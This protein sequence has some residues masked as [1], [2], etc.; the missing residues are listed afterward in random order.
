MAA[1]FKLGVVVSYSSNESQFLAA[2][3]RELAICADQIVYSVGS[4]LYDM[5]RE[6]PLDLSMLEPKFTVATYA[7]EEDVKSNPR[8]YH[9]LARSAGFAA[10][11][12]DVTWVLFLDADEIPDGRAVKAFFQTNAKHFFEKMAYKFACHWYFVKSTW[13][14]TSDEDSIVLVH[15]S[16]LNAESLADVNERDGIVRRCPG[17][18][19]RR[20]Y[21]NAG[22]QRKPMFHHYSWVRS[23]AQA[24]HKVSTW[25]HRGD[26][27]D[28]ADLVEA[29]WSSPDPPA[30]DFVDFV[31][32][33]A[34]EVVEDTF[35]LISP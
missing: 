17:G 1:Q 31:H 28:W 19:M 24:L 15:R 12:E 29:A 3:C 6:A 23:K 25:G 16:Q 21:S 13:R 35:D 18:C 11:K 2:Q 14:A 9:N 22:T 27:R 34:Y 33:Y 26:R 4:H 20:I 10:L 7:V 32:G 5:R 30:A 8:K